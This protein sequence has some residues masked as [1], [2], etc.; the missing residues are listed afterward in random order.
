MAGEAEA[1]TP[2]LAA[3]LAE[4]PEVLDAYLFGSHAS[5]R[6]TALSDVDV[7]VYIDPSLVPT[8]PFGY[9]AD[10]AATLGRATG[11]SNV[12]VVVL[13][14]ATP[15]LYHRVIT[16][17]VRIFARDLRAA[18]TRAGRALSRYCDY[19]PQLRRVDAALAARLAGGT[20]GR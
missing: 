6:A 2:K 7:A 16:G 14:Q 20:F 9:E 3:A 13:N 4:R 18:T 8:A 19:L 12:D 1:F 17:G 15:L 11:Q 5:S 10:L